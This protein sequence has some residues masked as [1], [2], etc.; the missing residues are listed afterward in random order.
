MKFLQ[1][2]TLFDGLLHRNALHHVIHQCLVDNRQI[3]IERR[4]LFDIRTFALNRP[5]FTVN[6][7][8]VVHILLEDFPEVCVEIHLHSSPLFPFGN[9]V[10]KNVEIIFIVQKFVDQTVRV[11]LYQADCCAVRFNVFNQVKQHHLTVDADAIVRHRVIQRR[12]FLLHLPR[13]GVV[14]N[15]ERQPCL[16]VTLPLEFDVAV[17]NEFEVFRFIHHPVTEMKLLLLTGIIG[18]DIDN[19]EHALPMAFWNCTVTTA[20][21]KGVRNAGNNHFVLL[22]LVIVVVGV[23]VPIRNVLVFF[24]V[25]AVHQREFEFV[26]EGFP[27]TV[28]AEYFRS[29]LCFRFAD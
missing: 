18:S 13:N 28:S 2:I 19:Q 3:V 9:Y 26:I 20:P 5:S 1:I 23:L 10:V 24:Q 6:N 22:F 16:L 7:Q 12:T 11:I 17:V 25:K 15:L 8:I 29:K 14:H 21:R 4:Q 27:F